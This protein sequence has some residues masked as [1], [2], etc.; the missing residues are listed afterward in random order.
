MNESELVVCPGCELLHLAC[1]V[2]DCQLPNVA[3]VISLTHALY[4]WGTSSGTE[5]AVQVGAGASTGWDSQVQQAI[6]RV[7]QSDGLV[8]G[9]SGDSKNRAGLRL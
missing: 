6:E 1:W 4:P 3:P 2:S 7:V 9:L 8:G 5:N